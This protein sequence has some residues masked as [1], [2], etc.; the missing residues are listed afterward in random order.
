M[1]KK[2]EVETPTVENR[3]FEEQLARLQE[4]AGQLESGD[5]SLEDSL[6][7]YGEGAR[8][9]RACRVRLEQAR[10]TVQLYSEEGL[11]E[12]KPLDLEE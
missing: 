8:L 4:I 11:T 1:P 2:K 7:L 10:H 5:L 9:S 6:T 12:F 3:T